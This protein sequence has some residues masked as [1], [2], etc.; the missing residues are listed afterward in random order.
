MKTA[1]RLVAVAFCL[2]VVL[3]GSL[4]A[5]S[6]IGELYGGYTYVKANPQSFLPNTNMN[7]WVASPTVYPAWWFGVDLEVSAV[8][9]D[10]TPPASTGAPAFH[11][12]EYSYLAGPQIRFLNRS[13]MQAGGKILF[14]GVF[15]QMNPSSQLT[16]AGAQAA[17][18]FGYGGFSQTKFAALFA[19]PI[20]FT[21]RKSIGWR[22]EPGLYLTGFNQTYQNNLRF[23]TGPV[24]RFGHHE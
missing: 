4:P 7:G 10:S 13:K 6:N 1:H 24:F 5:Q 17:A 12:K 9:G 3:A 11:V 16:P 19:V 8:F 14:G 23:S 20:D 18:V 21:I 22:V 15:G 2:L